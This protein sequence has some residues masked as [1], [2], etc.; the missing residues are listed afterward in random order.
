MK[1]LLCTHKVFVHF[2]MTLNRICL[3][4][5]S[6]IEYKP[7]RLSGQKPMAVSFCLQDN[8]AT[9]IRPAAIDALS[10]ILLSLADFGA[11]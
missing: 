3:H 7:G 10:G 6:G 8:Y 1:C 11:A 2:V 4:S 5:C 9:V